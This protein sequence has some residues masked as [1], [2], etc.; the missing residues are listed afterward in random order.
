MTSTAYDRRFIL[1]QAIALGALATHPIL[2]AQAAE[3]KPVFL[4]PE[5]DRQLPSGDE[6]FLDHIAHFVSD[7]DAASRAMTRAGFAPAPISIQVN[8]DPNG[9]PPRLTG[10]GNVTAMMTRGYI[11]ILFKTAD[12][13]LGHE[14]DTAMARYAGL[15]LAA[16]AVADAASAH[17]RLA[18][19]GFKV[20][21]LVQMQRPVE[22]ANGSGTAAFTVARVE[23]DAMAEG[24][25]QILTHRTE[26]TV[27]QPRWL[28]HPNG[29]HGLLDL[30]IVVAD[31]NEAAQRFAKFTA[32][33][34]NPRAFGYALQLDRG[35]I[36]IMSRDAFK[37]MLPELSVPDLPFIGAYGVAVASLDV[38]ESK[39]R[40]GGI[41]LH[42]KGPIIVARFPLELGQGAWIF[43]EQASDLP[44][45]H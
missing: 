19:S 42:R 8:P 4:R 9:G 17:Q 43:V 12:T 35:Q 27:W 16:F 31:P 18:N 22:T 40:E 29:A 36:E 7:R 38:A 30:A 13:P 33:S 15:H 41:E 23:P 2:G 21:P 3:S 24:R 1:K 34:A 37:A 45:R 25:I 5:I 32:R 39:L 10:T 20:R 44:W 6:I 26:D 28:H 11:E 14:L